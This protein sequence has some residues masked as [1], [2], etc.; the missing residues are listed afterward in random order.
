[1][2]CVCGR[3]PVSTYLVNILQ[4]VSTACILVWKYIEKPHFC[5]FTVSVLEFV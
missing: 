2:L 5:V 4:F 1:M 3:T